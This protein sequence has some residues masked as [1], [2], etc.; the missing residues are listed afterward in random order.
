M[1]FEHGLQGDETL[2]LHPRQHPNEADALGVVLCE[3]LIQVV[4]TDGTDV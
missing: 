2:V 4:L 1:A 3:E